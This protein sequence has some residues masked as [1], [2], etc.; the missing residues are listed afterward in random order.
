MAAAATVHAEHAIEVRRRLQEKRFPSV[1]TLMLTLAS[2]DAILES[3]KLSSPFVGTPELSQRGDDRAA[4]IGRVEVW[5][6]RAFRTGVY[7]TDD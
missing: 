7:R 2:Q 6:R 4:N 1:T 3:W 5:N